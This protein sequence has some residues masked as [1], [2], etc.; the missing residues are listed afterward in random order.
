MRSILLIGLLGA[1]AP[2]AAHAQSIE[3]G[4]YLVER[5]GMCSDCHTPRD[6]TGQ[7]IA[8]QALQG[9][10][11]SFRPMHSMPFAE[12]APSI[13]GLPTHYSPVQVATFLQTGKRL[14]GS[15]ARPPM[16]PYRMSKTDAWS[17]VRYLQSMKPP[18]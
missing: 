2:A 11:I 18:S 9:A 3:R 10:P 13:A 5:V 7:T 15:M 4:K 8:A 17:V 14:D 16:P 6:A 1:V 12:Q